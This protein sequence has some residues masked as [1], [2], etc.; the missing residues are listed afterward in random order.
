MSLWPVGR[1]E[2]SQLTY[3]LMD[4]CLLCSIY[5]QCVRLYKQITC[6]IIF[7][8]YGLSGTFTLFL[9]HVGPSLGRQAIA[10]ILFYK[11]HMI[12]HLICD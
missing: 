2:V 10:Y 11:G 5:S 1:A 6:C 12:Y 3:V 8:A 4:L 7:W 9:G